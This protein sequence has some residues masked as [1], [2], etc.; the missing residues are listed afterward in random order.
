MRNKTWIK[1]RECNDKDKG[2]GTLLMRKASWRVGQLGSL[3]PV[4]FRRGCLVWPA[5]NNW[6]NIH[7]RRWMEGGL[8]WVHLKKTMRTFLLALSCLICCLLTRTVF[9][10]KH[11]WDGFFAVK[12]FMWLKWLYGYNFK[13]DNAEEHSFLFQVCAQNVVLGMMCNFF[14][15]STLTLCTVTDISDCLCMCVWTA[16]PI[17]TELRT[18]VYFCPTP[19]TLWAALNCNEAGCFPSPAVFIYRAGKAICVKRKCCTRPFFLL[20]VF[21][22]P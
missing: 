2:G 12:W 1:E 6:N 22:H 3:P 5:L 11:L 16:F 17:L 18:A 7:A 4:W 14:L 21:L 10:C 19:L 9:T 15:N 13:V 8:D 20:E